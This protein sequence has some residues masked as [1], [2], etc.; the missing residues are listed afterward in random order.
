M[1]KIKNALAICG[2]VLT[3]GITSIPVRA[4]DFTQI[5]LTKNTKAMVAVGDLQT[6]EKEGTLATVII[7]EKER[8]SLVDSSSRSKRTITLSLKGT[9]Y[10]FTSSKATI[11]LK[12][13]FEKLTGVTTEYAEVDGKE[14]KQMINIILPYNSETTSI[15]RFEISN[16]KV[17]AT[18]LKLGDLNLKIGG[19]G[20]VGTAIKVAEVKE[21]GITLVS[22][23]TN[24]VQI[25]AGDKRQISFEMQEGVA[26]S[27]VPGR[28]VEV[29]L[30]Q[31]Y[32]YK[33][34]KTNKIAV[35]AIKLNNKDITNK[36]ELTPVTNKEGLITSF[37][38]N[39]PQLDTNVRNSIVFQDLEIYTS[40]T[41]TGEIRITLDGRGVE[42]GSTITVATIKEPVSITAEGIS[43]QVGK[44][45]Q[46]GGK[47][48]IVENDKRMLNRGLITLKIDKQD[49][50]EFYTE[51]K[52][53]VV[54][55][56]A[57]IKVLGW[58]NKEDNLFKIQV[59]EPSTIASTI[60]ISDFRISVSQMVP[61]GKYQL[62]VGG[63]AI[64]PEAGGVARVFDQFI[65]TSL[66]GEE[67]QVVPTP[68]SKVTK[69]TKFTVG[70]KTYTIDGKAYTMDAEPY[71]ENGRTMVPLRYA[72]EAAGIASNNVKISQGVITIPGS[73]LIEVTLGSD[74]IKADG[75]A[76]RMIVVPAL[77]AGRTYV[78]ISEIASL[79]NLEVSWEKAAKT[80]VFTY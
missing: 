37:E 22:P 62:S 60:E 25:V 26:D 2:M 69:I 66:K 14:D 13:G 15:G 57:A 27:V 17:S 73:K 47:V 58:D 70:S 6:V 53:K 61:D 65:T 10:S 40:A 19:L 43:A 59:V 72:V 64:S 16:L 55:G 7:E 8:G 31:G 36:V 24:L 5:E 39:I 56:D 12:G 3:L 54:E 80:A 11:S 49:G 51:P 78:P 52:V 71:I 77:K 46:K 28:T 45:A 30:N 41:Q 67:N 32:F 35:G 4:A 29:S 79:L 74:I 68:P 18:Q 44:N 75:V 1:K 23:L 20:E 33:D 76:S 42:E 21:Y 38:F 34:E 63:D 48:T 9:L 50:I